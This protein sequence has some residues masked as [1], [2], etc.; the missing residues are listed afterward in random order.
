MMF[1]LPQ[2]E[3]CRSFTPVASLTTFT[4]V[5]IASPRAWSWNRLCHQRGSDAS[6]LPTSNAGPGILHPRSIATHVASL[7]QSIVS[8]PMLRASPGHGLRII[9]GVAN[10]TASSACDMDRQERFGL[11]HLEQCNPFIE[12]EGQSIGNGANEQCRSFT[13]VP[14]PTSTSLAQSMV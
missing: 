1:G 11:R 12:V 6:P 9:F 14:S 5:N 7:A 10:Q 8:A 13:H 3:Q 4:H 2:L